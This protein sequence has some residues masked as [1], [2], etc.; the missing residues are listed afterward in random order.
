MKGQKRGLR[1]SLKRYGAIKNCLRIENRSAVAKRNVVG[2]ESLGVGRMRTVA[3][4]VCVVPLR[5]MHESV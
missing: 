3:F 4:L 5:S 1:G 2:I